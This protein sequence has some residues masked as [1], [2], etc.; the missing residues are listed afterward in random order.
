MAKLKT[1]PA[2]SS[3]GVVYRVCDGHVEVVLCGRVE[4]ELWGLPKGTPLQGEDLLQTA[5]REVEEE[6]GLDVQVIAP[7]NKI[8]YWFVARGVRFHKTVHYY[9]MVPTGGDLARHDPEYDVVRWFPIEA[10][11]RQMSY[12]NEAE[13]VHQAEA[14]IARREAGLTAD[15]RGG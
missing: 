2:V 4:P 15:E 7:I 10:A 6:T 8:E 9:L 14:L 5:V 3:G 13:I 11:Y 1:A 12:R